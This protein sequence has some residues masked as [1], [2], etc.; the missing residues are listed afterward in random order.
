[1]LK[2]LVLLHFD[3]TECRCRVGLRGTLVQEYRED[4][5]NGTPPRYEPHYERF[6]AGDGGSF[7]VSEVGPA[8]VAFRTTAPV[9]HGSDG[10]GCVVR[11]PDGEQEM[12]VNS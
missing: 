12:A 6:C 9:G 5:E 10:M 8:G 4:R 7:V 3:S 2:E 11:A 1:M